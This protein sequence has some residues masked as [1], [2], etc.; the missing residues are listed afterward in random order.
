M[1]EL[2]VVVRVSYGMSAVDYD[3]SYTTDKTYAE[4]LK[5]HYKKCHPNKDFEVRTRKLNCGDDY[6][7]TPEDY[8]EKKIDE[9][10]AELGYVIKRG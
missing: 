7:G 1:N 10:M 2:Y 6:W 3:I 4:A 9:E 5:D 8:D